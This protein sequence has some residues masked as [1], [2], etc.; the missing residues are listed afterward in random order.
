MSLFTKAVLLPVNINS[1]GEPDDE[2]EEPAEE[3]ER[4]GEEQHP[5]R[6][7]LE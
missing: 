1:A 4:E 6:F 2:P 5:L 7:G 3:R